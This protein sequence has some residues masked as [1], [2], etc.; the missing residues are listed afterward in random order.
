MY[1]VNGFAQFGM[2]HALDFEPFL[3]ALMFLAT[4]ERLPVW[5]KALI[6]YSVAVGLWGCWFWN[7]FVRTN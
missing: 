4:K 7:S 2:R 3:V 5:G 6:C 1:Y